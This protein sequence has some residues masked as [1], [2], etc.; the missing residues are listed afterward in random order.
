MRIET[1]KQ[2]RFARANMLYDLC[3]V[4]AIPLCTADY[5]KETKNF[6]KYASLDMEERARNERMNRHV[7][8]ADDPEDSRRAA[9]AL[10]ALIGG[11]GMV[12]S[13]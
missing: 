13:G 8:D 3:D 1:I 10:K 2:E 4:A 6:F 11:K 5:Y 7:F 9:M 12:F